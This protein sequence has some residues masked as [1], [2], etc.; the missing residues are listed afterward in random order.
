MPRLI[1]LADSLSLT[2]WARPVETKVTYLPGWR[3]LERM[4][5]DRLIEFK[6]GHNIQ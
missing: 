2:L 3:Y 4:R 5:K 1:R 6:P